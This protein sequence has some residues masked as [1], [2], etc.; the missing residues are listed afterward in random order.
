MYLTS[1]FKFESVAGKIVRFLTGYNGVIP[2]TVDRVLLLELLVSTNDPPED[3]LQLLSGCYRHAGTVLKT[4]NATL[5]GKSINF[6][7]DVVS[8]YSLWAECQLDVPDDSMLKQWSRAICHIQS[9]KFSVQTGDTLHLGGDEFAS[10]KFL[11]AILTVPFHPQTVIFVSKFRAKLFRGIQVFKVDEK[12]QQS[13][14][15]C[16]LP[17]AKVVA[18]AVSINYKKIRYVVPFPNCVETSF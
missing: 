8:C 5:I 18:P 15:D 7:L 14:D 16:F 12:C 9:T 10:V 17:L 11:T 4:I 1:A 6:R 13:A 2:Q 3:A